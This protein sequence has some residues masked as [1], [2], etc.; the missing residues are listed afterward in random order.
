MNYDVLNSASYVQQDITAMF[1]A[2]RISGDVSTSQYDFI[3]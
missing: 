1:E 2:V 3:I